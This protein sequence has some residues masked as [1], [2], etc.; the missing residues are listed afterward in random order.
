MFQQKRDQEA[1]KPLGSITSVVCFA[2]I[3]SAIMILVLLIMSQIGMYYPR[4][5]NIG[6]RTGSARMQYTGEPLDA[7]NTLSISW[8]KLLDGHYMR[9]VRYPTITD[10]GSIDNKIEF[11]IED[12]TGADVT[13]QYNIY[14]QYGSLE[15]TPIP[16][17]VYTGISHKVYDGTPLSNDYWEMSQ[18]SE[19][20]SGHTLIVECKTEITNAGTV[21]NIPVTKVVDEKGLDVTYLYNVINVNGTLTVEPMTITV[22]TGS[23][24]GIYNGAAVGNSDYEIIAGDL[25]P[26]HQLYPVAITEHNKIG[27][28]ENHIQ[29]AVKDEKG[30]DMTMNYNIEQAKGVLDVSP[31]KLVVQTGSGSKKYDGTPLEN[32]S[33]KLIS[34]SLCPEHT[35]KLV[36]S[37]ITGIGKK[38]NMVLS[39]R[40]LYTD[41]NGHDIDVT[42]CYQITFEFGMLTVTGGE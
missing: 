22:Q 14:T 16:I 27:V 9:V 31:R 19:L 2:L 28:V 18:T 41:S 26:G 38:D 17:H 37:S 7:R 4:K 36:C 39:Y 24:F 21:M 8:G 12:E 29:F 33:Y 42:N 34:G 11:I 1:K 6:F 15:I 10:V 25:L 20:I 23:Y 32:N 13:E 40:V 5:I 35:L 30:T 3:G